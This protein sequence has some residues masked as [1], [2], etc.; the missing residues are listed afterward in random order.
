MTPAGKVRS[1]AQEKGVRGF[2]LVELLVVIAIIAI[3][4]SLLLPTLSLAKEH[5]RRASCLNGVKQFILATHLYAMDYQDRLPRPGTDALNTKDTHTPILSSATKT[6][7]LKYMQPLRSL[8]CPNLQKSFEKGNDW[9]IQPGY[10]IAIGYHYL[11]GHDNTPWDPPEGTTNKWV[12]PQRT[13]ESPLLPLLADL[14]IYAYSFSR[15]LAPHTRRGVVV[16]ENRYFALHT[17]LALTQTPKE[18][19]AQGGNVGRLDG[20]ASWRPFLMMQRYRTSQLWGDE[21]SFG[22]W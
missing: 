12:S 1:D 11:G 8:D 22:Y 5:S 20:S 15:I 10:G 4:A 2:T 14:N 9:R 16:W 13:S 17:K 3:L 7:I 21:G 6:N 18:A 19:G